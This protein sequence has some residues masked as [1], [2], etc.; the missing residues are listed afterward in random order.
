M[1]PCFLFCHLVPNSIDPYPI[2]YAAKIPRATLGPS[3]GGW[4]TNWK[5]TAKNKNYFS[6]EW[7][8]DSN[9]P[10]T[11]RREL[12]CS[13]KWSFGGRLATNSCHLS[14]LWSLGPA[15]VDIWRRPTTRVAERRAV[16][17][18]MVN[19]LSCCPECE[20]SVGSCV[21]CSSVSAWRRTNSTRLSVVRFESK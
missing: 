17:T 15:E 2:Q 19:Y 1:K 9:K 10:T 3:K 7:N 8:S 4:N 5:S 20:F 14:A 6:T 13:S 21:G 18:V 16:F 12:T 11:S